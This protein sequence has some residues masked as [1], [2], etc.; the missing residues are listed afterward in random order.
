MLFLAES[1]SSLW[2]YF[3]FVRYTVV[4]LSYTLFS[5]LTA[6]AAE[7]LFDCKP[8]IIK[9]VIISSCLQSRPAYILNSLL[10]RKVY[11]ALSLSLATFCRPNSLAFDFLHHHVHIRHRR[12]YDKQKT[13]VV[14]STFIL[15]LPVNGKRTS[16]RTSRM[17]LRGL[18]LCLG[19]QSHRSTPVVTGLLMLQ[20][21]TFVNFCQNK[22][23]LFFI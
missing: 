19:I 4:F 5:Q 20:K 7:Y 12:D 22:S 18:K 6:C 9:Y 23:T 21:R 17:H 3:F 10:Y 1:L 13:V 8:Q 16:M 15:G 2:E 11:M 14:V